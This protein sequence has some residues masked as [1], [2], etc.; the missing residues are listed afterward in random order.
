MSVE[1]SQIEVRSGLVSATVDRPTDRGRREEEA[2]TGPQRRKIGKKSPQ[3][4]LFAEDEG[5]RNVS[6]CA[7]QI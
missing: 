7:V 6:M 3:D 4:T 5:L 1:R 2:A